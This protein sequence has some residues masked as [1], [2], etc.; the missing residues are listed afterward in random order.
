MQ[1]FI[2]LPLIFQEA[3]EE[4]SCGFGPTSEIALLDVRAAHN[5]EADD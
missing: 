5:E 4:G 3:W 1:E 2:D